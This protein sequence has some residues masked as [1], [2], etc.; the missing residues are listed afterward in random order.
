MA[1]I[2]AG[3]DP[4]STLVAS[5]VLLSFGLPFAVIPL[6]LFTSDRSLM[7]VFA[8]SARV[9]VAATATAAV[10]VSLNLY[11]ILRVFA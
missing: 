5:Q 3:L 4:T 2:V 10:I 8:N 11:L 1:V 7:G 6:V 9:K